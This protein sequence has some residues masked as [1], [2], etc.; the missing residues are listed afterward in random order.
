[1]PHMSSG[2]AASPCNGHGTCDAATGACKCQDTVEGRWSGAACDVC[3]ALFF[4]PQCNVTCPADTLGRVCGPHG[5]CTGTGEC[6]CLADMAHGFWAGLDCSD[7]RCAFPRSRE[8]G[9]EGGGGTGGRRGCGQTQRDGGRAAV[10]C[11]LEWG[12][13]FWPLP[14][15]L[16]PATRPTHLGTV[17]KPLSSLGRSYTPASNWTTHDI[18][19]SVLLPND[20]ARMLIAEQQRHQEH[21]PNV[22]PSCDPRSRFGFRSALAC[23]GRMWCCFCGLVVCWPPRA[24]A[25]QD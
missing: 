3:S 5:L 13:P 22:L 15:V 9:R 19:H 8:T 6:V 10:G 16:V 21:H 24:R 20:S 11:A 14:L 2:G 18:Y 12:R 17:P 4:G 25:R 7:C 23:H 1:M